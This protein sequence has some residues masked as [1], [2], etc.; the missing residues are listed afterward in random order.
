MDRLNELLPVGPPISEA[1]QIGRRSAI[2]SLEAR[3]RA[4]HVV[5]MLEPR[6]VGKTSVA[7]ASLARIKASGGTVAEVNL[8]T[9]AG[10]EATASDLARQLAGGVVQARRR[11]GGLLS[12]LR[13]AEDGEVIGEQAELILRVAEE[14]VGGDAEASPAAVIERAAAR[15][16]DGGLIAVLLDE[17]HV[18]ADWPKPAR[19]ALGSVLKDNN[20]L[21]AVVASSERRA[22]EQLTSEDGPLRYVG[23]RF[24]L[25]PIAQEDWQAGLRERFAELGVP[26]AADALD[27]LLEQSHGH[28][29]CTMLLAHEAARVS[30]GMDEAS[31]AAVSAALVTVRRDEAWQELL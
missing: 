2:D 6:R 9:R 23:T 4:G 11:L 3:L 18:L 17:A 10:P 31:A 5:K 8:A 30:A 12:G 25:P 16:K 21:G 26:I 27:F 22:L 7:R 20:M 13:R 24:A 14:L 29:Y 1:Q 15:V 28:P 19:F